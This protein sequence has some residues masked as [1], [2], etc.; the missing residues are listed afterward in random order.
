MDLYRD[1]VKIVNAWSSDT[2]TTPIGR[3]EIGNGTAVTAAINFDDVVVD[4]TPG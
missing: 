2:G 1:G 4:Q 3:V